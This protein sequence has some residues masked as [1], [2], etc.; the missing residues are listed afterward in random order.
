MHTRSGAGTCRAN[1]LRWK[2]SMQSS[3]NRAHSIFAVAVLLSINAPAQIQLSDENAYNPIPSPDASGIVA[4]RTG[5]RRPGGSGGL[6]RSNLVSNLIILDREGHTLSS[7]PVA[8]GFAADWT[9]A[10][11]VS[12]RDGA[13]A[14][15]SADGSVLQQGRVCPGRPLAEALPTCAERVAYLSTLDSFVSVFQK[16]GDSVLVTPS[17]DLSTRHHPKFLGQWLAPSPGERY[18]AVGPGRLGR[19]L[20]VY[21]LREKA[22]IEFGPIVIHPSPDW[23]WWEPGW[24]PWFADGSRLAFFNAQELVVSSSDGR[25]K[26]VILR[27]DDPAGLATPSP[28]GRAIAYATFASRP[29]TSGGGNQAMWDCTGI[30]VVRLQSPDRPQ[31]LVE[32]T[33]DLT[34]NLRW[35]DNEHLVFDRVRAGIPP[36]GRLWMVN[37]AR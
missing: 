14:L 1:R 7:K 11:I 37:V 36:K 33:S 12:F 23:E 3:S 28:D 30:W 20:S 15:T 2:I 22:W 13:Y 6:G 17:G 8:D 35:L 18:I 34:L 29:R 26:R 31:R 10:G 32:Q 27:T 25:R 5:W 24:S 16:F 9:K 21:D 19:S 4:V